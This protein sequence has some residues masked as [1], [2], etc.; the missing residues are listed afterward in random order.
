[1]FVA[2]R[3]L[4]CRS[5]STCLTPSMEIGLEA[6][7]ILVCFELSRGFGASAISRSVSASVWQGGFTCVTPL[8][9]SVQLSKDKCFTI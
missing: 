4:S 6:V 2:P 9:D 3:L 5:L 1:M 8:K 7:G